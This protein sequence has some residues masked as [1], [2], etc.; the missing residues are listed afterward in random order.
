MTQAQRMEIHR[1]HAVLD[2]LRVGSY[3]QFALPHY[4]KLEASQEI[5]R[6][7]AKLESRSSDYGCPMCG[8]RPCS[9]TC[10]RRT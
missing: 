5:D 4:S 7:K 9:P 6:L 10:K 2:G 8:Q 3:E 1:L